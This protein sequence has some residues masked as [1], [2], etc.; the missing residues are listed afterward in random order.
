MNFWLMGLFV[1]LIHDFSDIFLIVPRVM[2]DGRETKH[3]KKIMIIVDYIG[4][5]AWV[6]CRILLL[7]GCCIYSGINLLSQFT[8]RPDKFNSEI[9]NLVYYPIFF[10]TFMLSALQI[11]QLYWTYF[12]ARAFVGSNISEKI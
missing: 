11:V 6:G 2:R 5:V 10:M 1:L 7:S 8:F 4:G 9:V 12:I 3:M